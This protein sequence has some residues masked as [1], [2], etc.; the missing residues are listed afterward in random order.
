MAN[1]VHVNV[2]LRC[3]V[4]IFAELYLDLS[5]LLGGSLIITKRPDRTLLPVAAKRSRL[6]LIKRLITADASEQISVAIDS[7]CFYSDSSNVIDV[8]ETARAF[9]H[10]FVAA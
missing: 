9:A 6:A 5:Y 8:A 1:S 7:M 4:P 2:A 3:G 10:E